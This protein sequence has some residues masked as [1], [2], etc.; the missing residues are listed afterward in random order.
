M[1][2]GD[3]RGV[4]GLT[5]FPEHPGPQAHRAHPH[6]GSS[7]RAVLHDVVP[8]RPEADTLR[9]GRSAPTVCGPRTL[10]VRATADVT[11]DPELVFLDRLLRF[12]GTDLASFPGP[13]DDRV[14]ITLNPTRIVE[15]G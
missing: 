11:P 13:V 3:A 12:Y 1:D 10:E 7:Q 4:V 15:Q 5:P 6:P 9:S 14:V 2:H 8:S